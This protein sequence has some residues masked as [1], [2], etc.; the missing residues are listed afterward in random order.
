MTRCSPSL[1][2]VLG[3]FAWFAGCSDPAR[4]M[5]RGTEDAGTSCRNSAE[6]NDGIA[7][8]TDVCALGGV[9]EHVP[10]GC[11]DSGPVARSCRATA[12]C[13]DNIA[14]TRDSC[15]VDMVCRNTPQNEMCP[16]GQT[17]DP[18]RGCTSGTVTPPGM[19]RAPTDCDDRIDCT[20]NQCNVMNTCVFVPQNARCPTGQTCFAGMGCVAARA[21]S[22]NTDCDDRMRCNG[23][24]MCSETGCRGG[25]P[26]N[27]DDGDA[28]TVDACVESGAQMCTHTR[29]MSC[30]TSMIRSGQYNITPAL[31]YMCSVEITKMVVVNVNVTEFQFIVTASGLT[32][33]GGPT[34]MTGPAP[35][36]RMFSVSGTVVGDCAETFTL[37]G[38]FSDATHFT[39]IFT[40]NFAGLTCF[41]TNCSR[42]ERTVM[43]TARM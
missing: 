33:T 36:G 25:M 27:C 16:S 1:L 13:N 22:T 20:E 23:V 32:V 7:C 30:M 42:Q 19:C 41:L 28:C 38:T 34:T 14:C 6:C 17:C 5:F 37:T 35:T 26:A 2:I 29:D 43:G 8:T 10:N 3:M 9:C 15:S 40:I 39:G 31:M 12:D 11:V 18:A 21:C 24:E 4:P